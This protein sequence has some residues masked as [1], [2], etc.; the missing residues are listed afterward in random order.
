MSVGAVKTHIKSIFPTEREPSIDACKPDSLQDD[1]LV[2]PLESRLFAKLATALRRQFAR[3]QRIEPK[4]D[5]DT[6]Q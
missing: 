4:G 1:A 6:S 3:S 2:Q 5:N